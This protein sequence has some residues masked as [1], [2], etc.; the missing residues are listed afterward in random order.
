MKEWVPKPKDEAFERLKERIK[1]NR[2]GRGEPSS[3][4]TSFRH[5]LSTSQHSQ[6]LMLAR[7]QHSR[8][9]KHLDFDL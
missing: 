6:S 1:E 4:T 8:S 3:P 5:N 7:P 9:A 2:K